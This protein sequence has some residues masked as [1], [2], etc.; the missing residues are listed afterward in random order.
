[1]QTSILLPFLLLLLG[2]CPALALGNTSAV[3]P[4]VGPI[5]PEPTGI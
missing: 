2:G 5:P 3:Q 1:M 4:H